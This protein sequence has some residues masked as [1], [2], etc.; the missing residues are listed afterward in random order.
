[1]SNNMLKRVQTLQQYMRAMENGDLETV[2]TLL[3]DAE[4]DRALESMILE[5]NA[6]Y[7]YVDSIPVQ[8]NDVAQAQRLISTIARQ[9]TR[10][11]EMQSPLFPT[12]DD[13]DQTSTD[14]TATQPTSADQISV[15]RKYLSPVFPTK[16]V[17]KQKWYRS[18]K[19]WIAAVAAAILLS[20][21]LLQ[22]NSALA[23][24]FLSFF[25]I[26]Q[27][28][29]IQ[30][31]NTQLAGSSK[32]STPGIGDLGSVTTQAQSFRIQDNITQAQA[33]HAINFR[34]TLPQQLPQNVGNNPIFNVIG[35]GH[36][37]FTFS[38]AKVHSYLTKN[39]HGNVQIPANL[40]GATFSLTTAPGIIAEYGIKTGNP[41]LLVE[42]PSP[43]IQATGKASLQD[44]RDF[45]L[46][47]PGLPAPFVQELKQLD[48][49]NGTIPFPVPANMQAQSITVHNAPGL[50]LTSNKTTKIANIES[51][52]GS[53][54]LVWQE[55]GIIYALGGLTIDA[56]QLLT[57]ANSLH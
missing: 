53:N 20:F 3:E 11:D 32:Y 40:D 9:I 25:Q 19:R 24:Q 21:V 48:L 41:F 38:S 26:K 5:V 36:E 33:A 31:S 49:N 47:L 46:T 10:R 50:L 6:G 22:S 34:L 52:V 7:Q 28:K 55:N 30:I 8:A 51:P 39:G 13:S 18:P 44:L 27:F 57:A 14:L 15:G 16:L 56:N 4:Q 17:A 23:S 35:N 12:K 2:A 43:D 29:P 37:T 42:M 1:M 45:M 54:M